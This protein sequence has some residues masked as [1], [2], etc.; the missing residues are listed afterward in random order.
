MSNKK[1]TKGVYFLLSEDTFEKIKDYAHEF[2]MSQS[3]FIRYCLDKEI[4]RLDRQ[5]EEEEDE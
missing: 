1:K 4:E 3:A 5:F 2:Y